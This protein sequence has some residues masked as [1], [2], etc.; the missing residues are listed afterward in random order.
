MAN[1]EFKA[2]TEATKTQ[3]RDLAQTLTQIGTTARDS[4]VLFI[5]LALTTAVD[6]TDNEKSMMDLNNLIG[7][8]LIRQ[9]KRA[10]G[11]SETELA[12][13]ELFSTEKFNLN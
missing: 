10:Q 4:Q 12:I 6:A 9:I 11:F 7:E 2:R 3:L 5:A 1:N 8:F 13:D